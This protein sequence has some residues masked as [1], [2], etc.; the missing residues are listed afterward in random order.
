MSWKRYN[1][2]DL[3]ERYLYKFIQKDFLFLFLGT[4]N[5]WFSRAD[6]FGD[7]L[8]C[9]LAMELL[10]G[11]PDYGKI[12]ERKEKFL[13]SCW[14]LANNESLALWDKYVNDKSKRRIAAIRF[15]RSHLV[16]RMNDSINHNDR[17][18]YTRTFKHGAIKYKDLLSIKPST[19]DALLVKYPEFR[20]E[21]A[22]AY[23][24][25]YR[26]VI[27]L[28]NKYYEKGF[29]YHLLEPPSISFDI[30]INPLLEAAEYNLIKEEIHNKGYG[31]HLKDSALNRWL[32][33]EDW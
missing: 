2:I 18:H 1:A 16:E 29:P 26:F 19:F 30:L 8:E 11:K 3:K 31:N 6:E 24:N 20:K 4:K 15:E 21:K 28:E 25:E 9:V 23:E 27:G 32:H 17:F 10:Q 33:P 22:F 7:K 5:I 14:H 12:V 13:I